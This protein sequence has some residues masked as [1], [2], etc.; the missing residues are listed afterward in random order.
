[1]KAGQFSRIHI[2]GNGSHFIRL[3]IRISLIPLPIL[4]KPI[5]PPL[6]IHDKPQKK[7]TKR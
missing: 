2:P 4:E 6:A 5:E 7:R 3:P 1:M